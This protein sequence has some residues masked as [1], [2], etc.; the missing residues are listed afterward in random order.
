MRGNEMTAAGSTSP[1]PIGGSISRGWQAFTRAPW[2]FVGFTFLGVV[3]N[4]FCR[5]LLET[6]SNEFGTGG[7]IGWGL[8]EVIGLALNVLVSLWMNIGLLRGAWIAL[9]GRKPSFSALIRWDGPA[10]QRLFLM[11][12]LLVAINIVIGLIAL[13]SGGLLGLIRFELAALPF[14]AAFLV[15]LYVGITQLFHLPLVV[16]RG[17]TPVKAFQ[18]GRNTVDPQ[19]FGIFGLSALLAIIVLI[20]MTI[21]GSISW[22]TIS[23]FEGVGIGIILTLPFFVCSLVAAYQHLFDREDC[24]GFLNSQ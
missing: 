13:L 23:R 15:L 24:T 20:G 11:A 18:A 4:Y 19:F 2:V 16:A 14:L 9:A 22:L 21:C 3:L 7:S 1:L 5:W 17:D 6:G 10:M 8:I 12:L